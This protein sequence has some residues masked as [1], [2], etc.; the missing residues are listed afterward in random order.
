MVLELYCYVLCCVLPLV[1]FICFREL[2]ENSTD[3]ELSHRLALLVY[4]YINQIVP[5]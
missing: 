1:E 2:F 4:K 5:V 3:V